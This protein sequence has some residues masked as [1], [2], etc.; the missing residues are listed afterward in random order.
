MRSLL[1][2]DRAELALIACRQADQDNC[3]EGRNEARDDLIDSRPAE[4]RRAPAKGDPCNHHDGAGREA[5]DSARPSC[6]SSDS[7]RRLRSADE[8]LLAIGQYDVVVTLEGPRDWTTVRRKERVAGIWMNADS[9]RFRSAP[10]YYAVASSK[11]VR[12]LVDE[13]TAAIYELG[14]QD[15]Q[16]RF[17]V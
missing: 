17:A 9:N 10:G 6:A 8:L 12:D 13:R 11:P 16:H 7:R 14:L 4:E 3:K 2:P 1:L 15:L 5:S